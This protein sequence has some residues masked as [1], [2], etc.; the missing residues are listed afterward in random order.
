M[1][2]MGSHGS[3]EYLKQNLWLKEG[4]KVKTSIWLPTTKNQESPWFTYMH[5]ACQISLESSR[6]RLKLCLRTS[7]RSKVCTRSYGL[8]KWWES[9]YYEFWD[10]RLKSLR[11]NNIWMQS[12][13]LIIE[14]IIRRKV[15]ASPKFGPWWVLWIRVCSWFVYAPK[16]L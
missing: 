1:F 7:P 8:P 10:S 14:N 16:V 13:W 11:K 4:L 6:K 12:P 3:I 15:V 5:V 9:Q 2:K